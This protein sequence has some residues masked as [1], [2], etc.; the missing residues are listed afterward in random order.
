MVKK[1]KLLSSIRAKLFS[2]VAM[3]LVAVIMVVSSTYAWFTLS[4]APEVTG[5]STAIGANGALE[6]AL[7]YST[8]DDSGN[9]THGAIRDGVVES[10]QDSNTYWGNLVDVSDGSYGLANITLFP[11]QL[12]SEVEGSFSATAPL[13]TPVYGADGRVEKLADNTQ[14]ATYDSVKSGFFAND[15]LGVRGIGVAS[16][17]SERQLTYRNAVARAATAMAQAKSTAGASLTTYGSALASLAIKLGTDSSATYTA[18]DLAP[19]EAVIGQLQVAVGHLDVAYQNAI[20]AYAASASGQNWEAVK[21]AMASDTATSASVLTA[22]GGTLPTKMQEGYTAFGNMVSDVNDAADLIATAKAAPTASSI[23][24][25]LNPIV[26]PDQMTVCD[27][28]VAD[29]VT[30]PSGFAQDYVNKGGQIT[31]KMAPGAGVYADI[32]AQCGNYAASIVIEKLAYGDMKLENVPA[33][34]Q[35]TAPSPT[36]NVSIAS[37]LTTAGA[38]AA[39]TNAEAKPMTE[40]YGYVLDLAFRTNAVDSNLL[41]Q[42]DATDRIY[43]GN[44]NEQTQGAGSVMKFNITTTDMEFADVK[45]L[46]SNIRI[47]FFNTDSEAGS[48]TIIKEAELDVANATMNGTEVEARVKLKDD[49]TGSNIITELE[50]NVTTHISVLVYLDGTTITN[51]DVAATAT[52]SLVGSLNLQFASDANLVPMENGNLHIPDVSGS[53]NT[54]QGTTPG[55]ETESES[56]STS[57][58]P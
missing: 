53:G 38:P 25:A 49:T 5:M 16:G 22:F 47:V 7:R 37:E 28:K 6:M 43:D 41:L 57:T 4:T 23:K 50:Q 36:Y 46:M 34:M 14:F 27:W 40:F 58:N 9:V 31:V 39:D 8:M 32:A 55:G 17:L 10:T 42:T 26:N 15:M 51:A 11:S 12:N 45:D 52:T 56:E 13:L 3:L 48:Y 19:L 30:N 44:G 21:E 18:D 1:P 29:I 2:A 54:N 24:L 20:Y 35:T 33:T